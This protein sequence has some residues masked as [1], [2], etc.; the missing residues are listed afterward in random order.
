V[1][2]LVKVMKVMKVLKLLKLLKVLNVLN[3]LKQLKQF[4][5]ESGLL[6]RFN[7]SCSVLT[8]FLMIQR[9]K[10]DSYHRI[11]LRRVYYHT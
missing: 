8:L 1:L 4:Q 3:V 2:K 7:I 6:K 9:L 5:L 10:S 11:E